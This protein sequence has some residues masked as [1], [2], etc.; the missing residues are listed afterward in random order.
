MFALWTVRL[1]SQMK[2]IMRTFFANYLFTIKKDVQKP[3]LGN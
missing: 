3:S 1:F 2:F